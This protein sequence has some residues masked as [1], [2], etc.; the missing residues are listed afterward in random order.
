MT[1][2]RRALALAVAS[3]AAVGGIALAP[4]PAMAAPSPGA[5]YVLSNQVGGNAVIAYPRAA[6]GTLTAPEAFATGGT[7]TGSGLGSQGAVIVD[8]SGRYL[9]AVNAGSDSVTSFRI[10]PHGLVRVDVEP[11]NGDRPTSVTVDGDLLY[12]LNAGSNEIAG[13]R[14]VGGELAP[15]DGSTQPTSGPTSAAGQVSFTPRG[16]QLIVAE[17]G[18]QL[19]GVY[20]VDADGVAG[21]PSFVPSSGAV[22]FG[23]DFDNKGHV[24]VSEAAGAPGGSAVSSYEINDRDLGLISASVPTSEG[25]ACWIVTTT[26]GKFAYSGNAGTAS[27]TGFRVSVDGSLTILDEDGKT[28]EALVGVTD[29]AVSRDSRYLY[30]RLG[31]NGTVGIWAIAADGSLTDLG[32][33]PGLPAG[34]AGIAA[35]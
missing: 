2:S 20:P 24:I 35:A 32:P 26:N 5:V 31:G 1:T 25:A 23:F 4:P 6:D 16:D 33:V 30:G 14:V 29:L 7:G 28:G 10:T 17:R 19:L 3:T 18:S 13:F 9:Y 22:P 15:V 8:D 12:V 21:S 34:T 11:S 27:V